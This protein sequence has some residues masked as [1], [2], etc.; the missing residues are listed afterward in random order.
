MHKATL[1]RGLRA[2]IHIQ[3]PQDNIDVSL[4]LALD[5]L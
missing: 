5:D 4:H 1:Q 3:K 2:V